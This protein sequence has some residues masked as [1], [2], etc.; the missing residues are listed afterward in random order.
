M[1]VILWAA[2]GYPKMCENK[3]ALPQA[4]V[5][6]I[7]ETK[8]SLSPHTPVVLQTVTLLSSPLRAIDNP[9]VCPEYKAHAAFYKHM[10]LLL[11]VGGGFEIYC[12]ILMV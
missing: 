10:M 8:L 6:N 2:C 4:L 1:S 5:T 3:E 9:C 12:C 7:T 11:F